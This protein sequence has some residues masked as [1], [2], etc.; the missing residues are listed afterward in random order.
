LPLTP[1]PSALRWLAALVRPYARVLALAAT[2][3]LLGGGISLVMPAASGR[4]VDAAIEKKPESFNFVI[5]GLLGLFVVSG[6][7]NYIEGYSIRWA[8]AKLLQDLRARLHAHLLTLGPAFFESQRTGDL[9]S[10]LG[11]DVS[12]VGG[13]LTGQLVNGLQQVVVLVGALGI[14]VGVHPGLTGT[15]LLAMPPVILAAVYFGLRFEKLATAE[16]EAAADANVAA[17]ESLAGI[18]TVQAFTREP[19]ETKRYRERLDKATAVTL[20]AARTWGAFHGIIALGF[21]ALALVLW[22]G[23]NLVIEGTLKPGQLTSFL[24]YTVTFAGALGSLV[25]F[26]GGLKTAVGA[27]ERVRELLETRPTIE[28]APDAL[29]LERAQGQITFE[30]V[31]FSYPTNLEQRALEDVSLEVA[32]GKFLALV[33]PSGAGK[34]TLVSL[35]LR[36]HDPQAGVVRLDGTDTRRYRLVDLRQAIGLVPQELFLFGDTVAANIR[37]GRPGATDAEVR[38]AAEAAQAHGFIERLPQG[39]ASLVG[40][41]GVKLS[42]GERQRIAIARVFLK[43]P[44]VV[45]LDEATS[46]LDAESEHLVQKAFERLLE[47]RTTIAI[48]HRL[49]TVR[50][51][52]QVVLLERGRVAERGTHEELMARGGLYRRLCELQMLS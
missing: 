11:S 43:D 38:A 33:G 50:R 18:R 32:P 42:A 34:S 15:M 47:G 44:G 29:P 27:T 1:R 35:L 16:R 22:R 12:E 19:E 13:A 21:S 40:E 28:N 17:E 2:A 41:R 49:A 23:G 7:L 4:I 14:L 51:A 46:S 48:A 9:L 45:L 8:A 20:R 30:G 37:Y 10:R 5:V 31:R 25:A 52:D 39:Y 26:W 3:S 24:L 6:V 36:F